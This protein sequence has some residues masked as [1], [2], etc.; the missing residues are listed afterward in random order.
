M[1]LVA[2]NV[3]ITYGGKTV[4]IHTARVEY[5]ND[6]NVTSFALPALGDDEPQT[7][8]MDMKMITKTIVI[9]GKLVGNN[10]FVD[11][12][13]IEDDFM[14]NDSNSPVTVYWRGFITESRP[15]GENHD[16]WI[17]RVRLI[18]DVPHDIPVTSGDIT[19]EHDD[20]VVGLG[21]E[22]A[23]LIGKKLA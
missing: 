22:V 5:T 3:Y 10:C 1:N 13:T 9:R 14:Y 2:S 18:D 12:H 20:N 21:I 7:N 16:C 23:C 19:Y 15:N 11:F 17:T 8:V 6:K 4:T